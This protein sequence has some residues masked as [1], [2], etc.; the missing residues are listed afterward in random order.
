MRRIFLSVALLAATS[1]LMVS[2]KKGDVGPEGP[3]GPAGPAGPT[4]PTGPTGTANVIYSPWFKF[5]ATDWADTTVPNLNT[6]KRANKFTTAM[7]QAVVDNGLVMAYIKFDEAGTLVGP[8]QLPLA[9]PV[10]GGQII[11]NTLPAVG[12][13]VYIG[14]T[15]PASATGV[16]LNSTFQLRYVIIPGGT[17]G[18]GETPTYNGFTAEELKAMPYE[19]VVKM[20][21]L[22]EE[23]GNN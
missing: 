21:N 22:S 8:F 15:I 23:G 16:A 19:S 10:T 5:Q 2:C 17:A 4:G 13:V 12:R 18:R 3:A 20:F 11:F 7:T 6:V 1:V 9:V 14:Y